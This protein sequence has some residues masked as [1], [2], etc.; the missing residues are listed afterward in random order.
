M[1]TSLHVETLKKGILFDNLLDPSGEKILDSNPLFI[2]WTANYLNVDNVATKVDKYE[3]GIDYNFGVRTLFDSITFEWLSRGGLDKNAKFS[4]V[5]TTVGFNE[6][7]HNG[8]LTTKQK[9]IAALGQPTSE[10]DNFDE[11][12]RVFET[13]GP[14]NC[15]EIDSIK[16]ILW[17]SDFRGSFWY[18][19]DIQNNS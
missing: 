6:T 18:K 9:I 10:R 17:G 16:V 11:Y 12:E 7:G 1:T 14:W 3:F 2:P 8:L 15:W 5:T 13:Y 19:L 4:G